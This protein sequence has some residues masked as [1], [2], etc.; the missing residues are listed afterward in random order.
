MGVYYYYIN[1]TK[2]Q[3]V[4]GGKRGENC[5]IY[6]WIDGWEKTDFIVAYGDDNYSYFIESGHDEAYELMFIEYGDSY[7][8]PIFPEWF[9]N[10]RRETLG[11]REIEKLG[12]IMDQPKWIA[13]FLPHM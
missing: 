4:R 5:D 12:N 2:A 3:A 8:D 13:E 11:N 10:K 7:D 9:N 1:Y 6:Q